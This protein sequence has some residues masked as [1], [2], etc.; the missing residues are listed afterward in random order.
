M[1]G[2]IRDRETAEIAIQASLTGHLV[3][4]TV[5]TNDAPGAITRLVDMGVEPY[6]VGSSLVGVLAQRLVRVLC[7]ECREA[8]L[9]TP[10]ELREVTL[11]PDAARQATGGMIYRPVGC[12]ACN[13]TGYR[14]RNGIY[15]IMLV[16]DDIRELVVKKTDSG[17]IKRAAVKH[18]MRTLMDDGAAKVLR[19]MTSIAEVLSVT[20][21]DLQ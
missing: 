12:D 14:G 21:E 4:S 15:E 20:Q 19:G 11:K 8:Y 6:L 1:V 2:E 13:K 16:D 17:T 3:F 9:P 7:K 5:H 10:E 18:G